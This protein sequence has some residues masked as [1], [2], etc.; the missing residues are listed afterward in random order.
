MARDGAFTSR[1]GSGEGSLHCHTHPTQN[2]NNSGNELH[3]LLQSK[4]LTT[5]A[6]S[7]RTGMFAP[8][9]P[10]FGANQRV[11]PAL[12]RGERVAR[13]GAF[14]SRRGSGEGLLHCHTH[15]AQDTNNSG[16]E[17]HDLLQAQSL[18]HNVY[19]KR[20]ISEAQNEVVGGIHESDGPARPVHE[21]TPHPS[22][23][24]W[25]KRPSPTP[26]PTGEGCCL[27]RIR[28]PS[29]A[30]VAPTFRSAYRA[31]QAVE[32]P[33]QAGILSPSLSS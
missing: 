1:R 26:L 14:T 2:T 20:T 17:L 12:S 32:K 15:P 24:G 31:K 25:R 30:S 13:D 18:A 10:L 9:E 4:A 11:D 27:A 3:D 28:W 6:P 7:K 5:N 21:P 29:T 33:F 19:A 16:N 22:C 23:A 8:N